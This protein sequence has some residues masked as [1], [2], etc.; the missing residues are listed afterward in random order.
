MKSADLNRTNHRWQVSLLALIPI[1]VAWIHK[2]IIH[3][4]PYWSFYY[5]PEL[6]YFA[7][8]RSI[9]DGRLPEN[10][11]NPG[12]PVHLLS[13]LLVAII[14]ESP[15]TLPR[16]LFIAHL[17]SFLI[18]VV[19][20]GFAAKVLFSDCDWKLQVTGVWVFYACAQS[21]E[22]QNIFSPE[23]LFAAF[24]AIFVTFAWR[25]VSRDVSPASALA[26]GVIL[27]LCCSLKFTFLPIA[28]SLVVALVVTSPSV[29]AAF[30][31]TACTAIGVMTGFLLGTL[32]VVSEYNRLFDLI[33]RVVT[34]SGQY[35]AGSSM[36]LDVAEAVSHF[37]NAILSAKSWYAWL[38]L[39]FGLIAI[40]VYKEHRAG[41]HHARLPAA[42]GFK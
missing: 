15:E 30:R 40:G 22:Y 6:I 27:G 16:F 29:S 11:D 20:V 35:G 7:G 10:L 21:L 3:P 1:V 36:T 33:F 38:A 19:S 14:G 42:A 39:T 12:V 4:R 25:C 31:E 32:P 8:G 26:V 34:H 2:E 13:A 41:R 24:G 18:C 37:S 5:D 9:M 28:A 23:G 17:F